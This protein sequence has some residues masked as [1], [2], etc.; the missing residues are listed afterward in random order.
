MFIP[1]QERYTDMSPQEFEKFSLNFLQEQAEKLENS[2]FEHNVMMESYDGNYQIDGKITFT[3]LGLSFLCL[4]ECKRY[5]GPIKRE[6]IAE[7]YEKMHSLGAQKGI[8]ITTSYYQKGALLYAEKH[9]IALITINDEGVTYHRRGYGIADIHKPINGTMFVPVLTNA[10]S[11]N[12]F[13]V[14]YLYDKTNKALQTFLQ[15][16]LQ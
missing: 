16:D 9:G 14:S 12:K 1:G 2:S 3:Y 4:V 11:E 10:I 13:T 5:N 6:K 8:F 15:E 7:L